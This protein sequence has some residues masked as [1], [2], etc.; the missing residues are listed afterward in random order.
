MRQRE[1]DENQLIIINITQLILETH[2]N[3]YKQRV[4]CNARGGEGQQR[5]WNNG[6][7]HKANKTIN[8]IYT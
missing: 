2:I 7:W 5:Y 3:L 1:T 6:R 4:M 8:Y